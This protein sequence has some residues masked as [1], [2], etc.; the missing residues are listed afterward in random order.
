MQA[1]KEA[2]LK[3]GSRLAESDRAGMPR[4]LRAAPSRMDEDGTA[5]T[6]VLIA[7]SLFLV[8]LTPA[9][10]VGGRAGIDPL[11]RSAMA[12]RDARSAGDVVYAMPDGIHCRHV[13]FDNTTAEIAESSIQH[14]PDDMVRERTRGG[15]GFAWGR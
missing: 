2:S 4:G 3:A 11:L 1:T 9:L 6:R 14:C 10:L 15:M 13:S 7:A 8:V 12:A 5:S